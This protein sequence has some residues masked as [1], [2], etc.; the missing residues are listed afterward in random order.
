MKIIDE[1]TGNNDNT[2]YTSFVDKIA[3]KEGKWSNV[4]D[5]VFVILQSKLPGKEKYGVPFYV[6]KQYEQQKPL[7]YHLLNM[8]QMGEEYEFMSN[9]EI[10]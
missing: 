6:V 2:E 8:K 4:Y 1:N 10:M 3:D 9:Y 5:S 7:S